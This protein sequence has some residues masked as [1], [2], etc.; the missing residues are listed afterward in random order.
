MYI[1]VNE[2]VAAGRALKAAATYPLVASA[3]AN[4]FCSAGSVTSRPGQPIQVVSK[5]SRTP[6]N[7]LTRPPALVV[8]VQPPSARRAALTGSLLAT[9]SSRWRGLFGEPGLPAC[10]PPVPPSRLRRCGEDAE[11]EARG[12]RMPLLCAARSACDASM[13][14][15]RSSVELDG[16]ACRSSPLELTCRP[17]RPPLVERRMRSEMSRSTREVLM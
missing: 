5:L 11:G 14:R 15:V 2:A 13:R 1:K 3:A 7:A 4:F 6:S 12:V 9:T 17:P 16:L 8:S 10:T